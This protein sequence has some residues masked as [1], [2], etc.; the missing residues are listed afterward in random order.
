MAKVAKRILKWTG[1]LIGVV[2]LGRY[3]LLILPV[4]PGPA[5]AHNPNHD[6][7]PLDGQ[8][9]NYWDY[10]YYP[11]CF[12][13]TGHPALTIPMGLDRDGL[14]V[15]LQVVGPLNSERRLIEFARL[16]EPLHEGFVRPSQN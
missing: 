16:I 14:P 10:F 8:R 3:D 12:N 6:A 13:A 1:L 11:M 5:I 15:A 4:T 9:I 2:A 7:I